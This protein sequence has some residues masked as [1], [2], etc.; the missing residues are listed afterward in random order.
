MATPVIRLAPTTTLRRTM[1]ASSMGCGLGR[2]YLLPQHSTEHI[3]TGWTS[4]PRT[5]ARKRTT[6]EKKK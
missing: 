1:P 6:E 5:W 2:P 3:R 4:R